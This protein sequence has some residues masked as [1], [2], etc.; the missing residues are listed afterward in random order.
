MLIK[1]TQH[2]LH[3]DSRKMKFLVD[4]RESNDFL[5]LK[6]YSVKWGEFVRRA[7]LFLHQGLSSNVNFHAL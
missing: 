7:S 1:S 2:E 6:T 4:L 3:M 5:P